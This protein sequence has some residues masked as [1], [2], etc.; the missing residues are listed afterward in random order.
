[1]LN[2]DFKAGSNTSL[3]IEGEDRDLVY[4]L[5]SDLR[6]YLTNEVNV[7]KRISAG[8]LRT[9]TFSAIA[10]VTLAVLFAGVLGIA[11]AMNARIISAPS[12]LES[13]SVIDKLN[14]LISQNAES[15]ISLNRGQTPSLI[16]IAVIM[17]ALMLA[18]Q[19]VNIKVWRRLILLFSYKT[20]SCL[21]RKSI[22]RI[23]GKDD[24]VT[25]SGL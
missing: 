17:L 7:C 11:N 13:Q 5:Y 21:A 16:G 1:M 23:L 15:S 6:Q 25:S 18:L 3:T 8:T 14:F 19:M 4:L 22:G 2:L 9:T 24:E 12:V 20:Y 10:V